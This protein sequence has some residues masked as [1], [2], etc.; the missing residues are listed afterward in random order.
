LKYAKINDYHAGIGQ[1]QALLSIA[2]ANAT[3]IERIAQAIR[4]QGPE[5]QNAISLSVAEKYIE[6]FSEIAK[7]GTTLLLP[8]NVGDVSSM[9]ASALK[10]YES[11]GEKR[12]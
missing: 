2:Q 6:A 1:A 7:E 5:G 3:S 12:K 4:T 9:V 8:S 11:V 10:V